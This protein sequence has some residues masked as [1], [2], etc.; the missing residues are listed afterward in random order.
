MNDAVGETVH[1]LHRDGKALIER[2][3]AAPR[4]P[5]GSGDALAATL[6]RVED[7]ARRQRLAGLVAPRA[8]VARLLGAIF[9]Y[10]PFLTR[11]ITAHPDWLLDALTDQPSAHLDELIE[12][13]RRACLS[14]GSDE[15]IMPALRHTRQRVALLVA[16]ADLGGVWTLDEVTEALT[17]LADA[18]VS[19]ATDHVLRDADRSGRLCLP[20]PTRPGEGVGYVLIAMGKHGAR[21][22]NYSS[23]ID[24]I[25]LHD[26]VGAPIAAGAEPDALFA[27]LTRQVVRLLQ[28]R[29]ADDYVLRVDLRLRPDPSSTP[30]SVALPAAYQYYE[31]V[32][33]N[34]E[35]AAYIKARPVAGDIAMGRRF[36]SELAPFIWRRHLDFQAIGALR[37]LW[38][39]VRAVHGDD[40][41]ISGRNVKL[42]PGGI[43]ECELATQALQLVFGGRDQRLRGR[44]TMPMLKALAD[45]GHLPKEAR[46]RLAAAYAFLRRVEHRLQMRNDEQTQILPRDGADLDDF[47][48]WC[49]FASGKAFEREF[50]ARTSEVRAEAQ[51]A[52]GARAAPALEP[53]AAFSKERLG[54]M[55]FHRPAESARL[56]ASWAAPPE[57]ATARGV[58]VRQALTALLSD[59]IEAFAATDDPDA[60][61][62]AFDRTF[63]RMGAPAE[64]FSILSESEKLRGLFA[65]MLG[66]APRLAEAIVQRPHLLDIFID[67]RAF[68]EAQSPRR[69][70]SRVAARIAA[71]ASHEEAL[72]LLRDAGR[73]E[74]FLAGARFL[75]AG[76]EATELGA[77]YTAVAEASL[78]VALEIT[79]KGFAAEHGSV[80]GSRLAVI[81]MGRLG[82]GEMT[83][84]SDLDLIAIYD[85]PKGAVA[86][87]GRRPLDAVL[88]FSRLTHRLITAIS[89]PTSHGRL[90]DIDMRL[91]PSGGKGPVALP[92]S[93]FID[94]Q[95]RDAET[96]EHLAM[97]RARPVAGDPALCRKV[98]A[99]IKR[100]L[101][102][103]RDLARLTR[104][105]AA[106]RKLLATEKGSDDQADLKNMRGGL[107]DIDFCAQFLVLAHAARHG[108]L[109][110]A[111]TAA[112]LA[113]ASAQGL[114]AQADGST[115]VK[116]R[117]LFTELLQRER[118]RSTEARP[119]NW[120]DASV[121][122][123]IARDLRFPSGAALVREV[124]RLRGEVAA[125]YRRVVRVDSA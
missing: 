5:P 109:A 85:M 76:G 40:E 72:D 37:G 47:A 70:E 87:D 12:G 8:K 15:E 73:E 32:G 11:I 117:A 20:D 82:S 55:G 89:A 91:R 78:R 23:D 113:E 10:S 80:P 44:R 14:A 116:A 2:I 111:S 30:P 19:L 31:S 45:A 59:L 4:L 100:I 108:S 6:D 61:I 118:L 26:P 17:R 48:R 122:R 75:G 114:M 99:A 29:T 124:E 115:A 53:G 79:Q 110:G 9:A 103:E 28:S 27:R 125:I 95:Q 96:W 25:A 71:A 35:R 60:A 86:S 66:S 36:L 41:A 93:A 51:K 69:V 24:V 22:L 67:V 98:A 65:A 16:L 121:V 33:Q 42:G 18:A 3:A 94:Y 90:Y 88:Y 107:V 77:A 64:L 83:A 123:D 97:T 13:L 1:D 49:G 39:E 74:W 54:A 106:M 68:S 57:P 43:R 62:A 105:V 102:R 21:E 119:V 104:D 112:S 63:D 34:W 56:I 58:R 120:N 101:A 7:G 38:R 81:A 84:T 50:A 46:K 52:F 92:L